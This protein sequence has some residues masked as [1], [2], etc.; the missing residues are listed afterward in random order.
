M[1]LIYFS[2]AWLGLHHT[3]LHIPPRYPISPPSLSLW[4]HPDLMP[5]MCL[6]AAYTPLSGSPTPIIYANLVLEKCRGV[7]NCKFFPYA[8]Q[9]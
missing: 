6:T 7:S 9:M 2:A 1:V 4:L 3:S 8:S 5:N